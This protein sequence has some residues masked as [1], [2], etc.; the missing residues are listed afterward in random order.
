MPMQMGFRW[1]GEGNDKIAR[2]S[3]SGMKSRQ[4]L[5]GRPAA[6]RRNSSKSTGMTAGKTIISRL[7]TTPFSPLS[8]SRRSH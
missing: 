2:K 8:G 7:L 3:S 1:Y 4:G 5:T 6:R